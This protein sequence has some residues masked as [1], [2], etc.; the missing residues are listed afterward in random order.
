[1]N[2]M[3][4]LSE[5]ESGI[6]SGSGRQ[7]RGAR[8]ARSEQSEPRYEDLPTRN[9]RGQKRKRNRRST[10]R[11]G[12]LRVRL[13]GLLE[14]PLHRLAGL[15]SDAEPVVDAG[16]IELD[17]RGIRVGIVGA[18]L[19]EEP[20]VARR[21]SVGGDDSIKGSLLGARTREPD[22]DGHDGLAGGWAKVASAFRPVKRRRRGLCAYPY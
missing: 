16:P 2:S 19:L 22:F 3:S 4:S 13:G 9:D 20:T 10:A 17:G 7:R 18:E 5:M 12:L 6:R 15:R 14:Q 21:S 11:S 8:G 1:M